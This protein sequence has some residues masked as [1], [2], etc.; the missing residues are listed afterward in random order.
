MATQS[1]TNIASID[2][3][4][5]AFITF[6]VANAGF[7]N[8]GT[9]TVDGETLYKISRTKDT[10]LTYWGFVYAPV[11]AS[12]EENELADCR[13]MLSNP[14]AANWDTVA[15]GQRL[16]TKLGFYE[17]AAPYTGYK[18][19]SDGT[20]VFAAIEVRTGIFTHLAIGN[21]TKCGTYAGSE[22]LQADYHPRS[23]GQFTTFRQSG[24][25][26]VQNEHYVFSPRRSHTRS[27]NYVRYNVGGGNNTDFFSMG[28]NDNADNL[29]SGSGTIAP[30]TIIGEYSLV[31]LS[32]SNLD[33][34]APYWD[35]VIDNS[36]SNATGLAPLM[37]VYVTRAESALL[38][39]R[40]I[41]YVPNI[42][43]VSVQDLTPGELVNTDWEV[44]P[45]TQKAGDI[46]QNTISDSWGIA[47]RVI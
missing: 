46:T 19:Y 36:P 33:A 32:G 18:F 21:L 10:V 38:Q 14:T 26:G 1:D 35:D 15:D 34:I 3:L 5:S 44:Y 41:G 42:A 25:G 12:T 23:S 39:Q 7:T 47:Y 22:F 9:D 40:I 37:P 17:Y 27:K 43:A 11:V 31:A 4:L 30:T 45:I 24:F 8:N 13:M 20:N 16:K 2:A 6:A 28:R 29:F